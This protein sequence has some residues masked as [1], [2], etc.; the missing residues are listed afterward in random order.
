V[1][2]S[3][4]VFT[5]SCLVER[6]S[7]VAHDVE[8]VKQDRRLARMRAV[9]TTEPNRAVANQIAHDDAVPVLTISGSLVLASAGKQHCRKRNKTGDEA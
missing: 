2:H 9:L 8:L 6:F 3:G 5:L 4:C 1:C 7:Q